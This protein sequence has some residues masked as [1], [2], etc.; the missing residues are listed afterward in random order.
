M[1]L[2]LIADAASSILIIGIFWEAGDSMSK[3][4]SY[5]DGFF[6][7]LPKV[8]AMPLPPLVLT[9][10]YV[11]PAVMISPVAGIA[12]EALWGKE[13]RLRAKKEGYAE[14]SAK[15]EERFQQTN[16]Q[17]EMLKT[18]FEDKTNSGNLLYQRLC[19][20]IQCKV[21]IIRGLDT[22]LCSVID[23]VSKKYHLSAQDKQNLIHSSQA[24]LRVGKVL[25]FLPFIIPFAA[26][27]VDVIV[28]MVS[29]ATA[30]VA[31]TAG[32][33]AATKKVVEKERRNAYMEVKKIYI[34]KI[35]L[36]EK[37]IDLLIEDSAKKLSELNVLNH[38][39]ITYIKDLGQLSRDLIIEI[40]EYELKL[41]YL[42]TAL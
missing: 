1:V 6:D 18:I 41:S 5:I 42:S 26:G 15:Y 12:A 16:R 21:D 3:D 17:Y 30:A 36:M 9:G 10:T 14:A 20:S 23:T 29:T 19:N 39:M 24:H 37:S 7:T 32:A 35:Q 28:G 4:F 34:Q 31:I 27:A 11:S 13:A 38:D 22:K 2:L 8:Y 25:G 33:H 40:S